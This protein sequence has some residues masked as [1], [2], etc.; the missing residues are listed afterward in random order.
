MT[1]VLA[2]AVLS[3]VVMAEDD[4]LVA[5]RSIYEG[6]LAAIE[7]AAAAKRAE[8]PST[9]AGMLQRLLGEVQARGNLAAWTAAD[10][11]LTRYRRE[12]TLTDAHVVQT[13]E[14]LGGVQR[15]ALDAMN[16]VER[17]RADAIVKL[18]TQYEARLEQMTSAYVRGGDLER[19]K[20]T[21]EEAERSA[22]LPVVSAARFQLDVIAAET[23][24]PEPV[25]PMTVVPQLPVPDGITIHSSLSSPMI[26]S[27]KHRPA[28][29][30]SAGTADG[31]APP[32]KVDLR[33]ATATVPAAPSTGRRNVYQTEQRFLIAC[34]IPIPPGGVADLRLCG[35]PGV[36]YTGYYRVWRMGAY[37]RTK[38]GSGG[39]IEYSVAEHFTFSL[40]A[41][42]AEPIAIDV[43]G[44]PDAATATWRDQEYA[45]CVLSIFD[46]YGKLVYQGTTLGALKSVAPDCLDAILK[47]RTSG[48]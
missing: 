18:Q 43:R 40:P 37:R 31:D 45:G 48:N 14:E 26:S 3:D 36:G 17:G 47:A 33:A 39:N 1:V 5:A 13:P 24:P 6:Q 25:S 2:C 9:Y 7:T 44:V 21:R 34:K 23:T 19:A 42:G 32:I 11:E 38:R 27:T 46:P 29:I 20:R 28:S 4:P 22:N 41:I 8:W 16:R 15:Q 10:T 35:K 12:K 30:F